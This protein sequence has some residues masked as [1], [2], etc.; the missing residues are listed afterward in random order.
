MA[1]GALATSSSSAETAVATADPGDGSSIQV[2]EGPSGRLASQCSATRRCSGRL[3]SKPR[4]RPN[5][6]D[7]GLALK[8]RVAKP[9]A[10]RSC[11]RVDTS[12]RIHG[13]AGWLAPWTDGG[14][15][16]ITDARLPTSQLADATPAPDQVDSLTNPSSP[17]GARSGPPT[18]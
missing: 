18:P 13:C 4:S 16:V 8:A 11:A 3:P 2:N 1:A 12:A 9:A 17:R 6:R 10:A 5:V 15:P 7:Q 14:R